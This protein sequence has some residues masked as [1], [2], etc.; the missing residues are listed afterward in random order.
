[1]KKQLVLLFTGLLMLACQNQS[2][3]SII[4]KEVNENGEVDQSKLPKMEFEE[5]VFNFGK[6][7]QG[8]KVEHTF[9]FVNSGSSDLIITSARGSCGCTVPEW[10]KY[11]IKPG[12]KGEIK[13]IFD[14]SGKIGKQHKTV[15]I[16]ANTIPNTTIIAIKGEVVG[17]KE[18]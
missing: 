17:P 10:P 9:V 18:S 4:E 5:E 13:V 7:S 2:D 6:I 3:T 8:E 1:M 12:E 15:T 16:V 11:P 14:S